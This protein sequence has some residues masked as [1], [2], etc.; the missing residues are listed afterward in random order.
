MKFTKKY[1]Q[2]TT[3]QLMLMSILTG[4]IA[5][6]LVV[7][8]IRV[9]EY[10]QLPEVSVDGAGQCLAVANYRNGEAFQCSDVGTVLRNFRIKNVNSNSEIQQVPV[11]DVPPDEGSSD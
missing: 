10:L 11:L 5:A 6:A 7:I 9:N 4:A 1:F 2:V 8:N 3:I